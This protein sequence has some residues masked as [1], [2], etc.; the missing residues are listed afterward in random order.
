MH[1]LLIPPA[2]TRDENSV[3]MVNAWIAEEALHCTLN[4]GFFKGQGHK[5]AEAWGT[6]L[7]DMVRHIAN[8]MHEEYRSNSSETISALLD[9]L[10]E[11]LNAPTSKAEGEFHA[12]PS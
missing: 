3:Q 11:E 4:I 10:H 12:R 8:A 7:A 9:A 6:V 5:E 1:S 2:A